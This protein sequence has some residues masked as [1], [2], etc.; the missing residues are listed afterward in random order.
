MQDYERMVLTVIHHFL[1]PSVAWSNWGLSRL[2]PVRRTVMAGSGR[3]WGVFLRASSA[4][5]RIWPQRRREA[6]P[7][8]FHTPSRCD[9]TMG[10]GPTYLTAVRA[11]ES[12]RQRLH[13]AHE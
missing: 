12:V 3:L 13:E 8:P 5:G 10:S 4:A 11:P 1:S 2:G 7:A 9:P 6:P